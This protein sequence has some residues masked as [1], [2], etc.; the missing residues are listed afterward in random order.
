MFAGAFPMTAPYVKMENVTV[1]TE[2][3]AE[4]PQP[5][6][7]FTAAWPGADPAEPPSLYLTQ[8]RMVE[9]SDLHSIFFSL[10]KEY[11]HHECVPL[12]VPMCEALPWVSQRVGRR[13]P[14]HEGA[15]ASAS[16]QVGACTWNNTSFD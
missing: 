7:I 5:Y 15:M 8:K 1:K 12:R 10:L 3:G 16:A 14:H 2:I 6:S 4:W 13:A 11:N 9:G